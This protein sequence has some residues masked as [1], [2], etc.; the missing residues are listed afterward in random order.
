MENA[1]RVLKSVLFLAA[2]APLALSACSSAPATTTT[3]ADYASVSTK[4]DQAMAT[5][6]EALDALWGALDAVHCEKQGAMN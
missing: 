3:T 6:Q 2:I 4:A 1:M 5:A